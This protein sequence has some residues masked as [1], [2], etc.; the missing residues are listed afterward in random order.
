MRKFYLSS[1]CPVRTLIIFY[2]PVRIYWDFF[3][4]FYITSPSKIISK[5]STLSHPKSVPFVSVCVKL[6][7]C[8]GLR[9]KLPLQKTQIPRPN[10]KPTL[11]SSLQKS[12]G[13]GDALFERLCSFEFKD[14]S[15]H[16]CFQTEY[17]V[18]LC[19]PP[20]PR[21]HSPCPNRLTP[22]DQKCLYIGKD[23]TQWEAKFCVYRQKD[24]IIFFIW[25]PRSI[26]IIDVFVWGA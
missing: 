9:V 7:T 4:A 20:S 25:I 8:T 24:K 12:A 10:K 22:S 3:T 26:Q 14:P 2:L 17:C 23:C 15:N 11:K 18:D 19:I 6:A 16:F 21:D 1:Y 13:Y 5:N